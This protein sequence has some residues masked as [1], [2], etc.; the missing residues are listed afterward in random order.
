MHA[1][2]DALHYVQN[3]CRRLI[4]TIQRTSQSSNGSAPTTSSRSSVRRRYSTS[5]GLRLYSQLYFTIYLISRITD[6]VIRVSVQSTVSC[7]GLRMWYNLSLYR[8]PGQVKWQLMVASCHRRS[9]N[10][11]VALETYKGIHRKFPDNV[12]CELLMLMYFFI[13]LFVRVQICTTVRRLITGNLN[14]LHRF[15]LSFIVFFFVIVP[16][17]KV[18]RETLH[19]HEHEGGA[20]LCEQAEK[21]WESTKGPGRGNPSI[22]VKFLLEANELCHDDLLFSWI[23]CQLIN[24]KR[25]IK[26]PKKL[27][28]NSCCLIMRRNNELLFKI[29]IYKRHFI[30]RANYRKYLKIFLR[31]FL[32]RF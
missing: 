8:R 12:E 4:D 15:S 26:N 13:N 16:R 22:S 18:S 21:G 1:T 10:Y 25:L 19:W 30:F 5:R 14:V 6:F 32:C 11:Q 28:S 7:P 2:H 29:I 27:D 3:C 23:H 24:V 20:G 31:L 17:F 9:G